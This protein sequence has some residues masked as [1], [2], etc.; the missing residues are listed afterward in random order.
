MPAVDDRSRE[1]LIIPESPHDC[2]QL[3]WLQSGNSIF[4]RNPQAGTSI[5]P[6]MPLFKVLENEHAQRGDVDFQAVRAAVQRFADDCNVSEIPDVAA[7]VN[8]GIAV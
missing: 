7:T 3:N 5:A 4:R 2:S 8:L 6:A 1:F